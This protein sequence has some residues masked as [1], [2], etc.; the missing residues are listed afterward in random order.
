[1]CFASAVQAQTDNN[2]VEAK[3]PGAVVVEATTFRCCLE[4]RCRDVASF[5]ECAAHVGRLQEDKKPQIAARAPTSIAARNP[6]SQ[7]IEVRDCELFNLEDGH[8]YVDRG[9]TARCMVTTI[10]ESGVH[11]APFT[12]LWSYDDPALRTPSDHRA[13]P[14]QGVRY[15]VV[16]VEVDGLFDDLPLVALA[17]YWSAP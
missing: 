3:V 17:S 11:S 6:R 15:D 10:N 9:P 7:L 2:P 1:M 5:D 14:S 12:V 13:N 4:G 16:L 8:G